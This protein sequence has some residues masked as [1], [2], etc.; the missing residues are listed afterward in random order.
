MNALK[1]LTFLIFFFNYQK[2]D[3]KFDLKYIFRAKKI[4]MFS[5]NVC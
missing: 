1:Y 2:I 5:E 3:I 4:D